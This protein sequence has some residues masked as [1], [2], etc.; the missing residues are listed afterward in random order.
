MKV[1]PDI[2]SF[3]RRVRESRH[4]LNAINND[5]LIIKTGLGITQDDFSKS[6][7]KLPTPIIDALSQILDSCDD[8]SERLHKAFLKLSCSPTPKCDWQLL[9]DGP[10][11]RMQHDLDAS[12][13]VLE[14]AID[15]IAL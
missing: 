2:S 3:A 6:G 10:L 11:L 14:L 4:G 1:I 7:P 12:K 8:T 13:I 9:K 5:L 15:Y